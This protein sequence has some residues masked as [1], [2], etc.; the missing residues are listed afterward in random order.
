MAQERIRAAGNERESLFL[1]TTSSPA[2]FSS[3]CGLLDCA[4]GGGWPRG[5]VIN[6]VGDFSTGKT[7]LAIEACA[8]FA[9]EVSDGRIVYAEGEGAFD[10]TYAQRVGL[11]AD[12]V[13]FPNDLEGVDRSAQDVAKKLSGRVGRIDTVEALIKD[14]RARLRKK[15]ERETLYVVDSMDSLSDDAE[16]DRD[17]SKGTYGGAKPKLLSEFFRTEAAAMCDKRF[18]LMII[19]QVRDAI[20]VTYGKKQRRSG[21]KALDFY[22]SLVV[23]LA[24]V[25]V[26][27]KKKLKSTRAIGVKIRAKVEKCK[28]GPA[29]RECEFPI[30][31]NYGIEDVEAAFDWLAEEELL[32]AAQDELGFGSAKELARLDAKDYGRARARLARLVRVKWEEIEQRFAPRRPKYG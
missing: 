24:K 1:P 28:V 14:V 26:L 13:E 4:I 23:W 15:S 31:F 8:N 2:R 17:F 12:R 5:R 30:H 6:V 22:A 25:E 11:P 32:Q 19:S 21:G 3:G 16:K 29:F 7:L 27:K 9:R 20:G 10:L 18:T